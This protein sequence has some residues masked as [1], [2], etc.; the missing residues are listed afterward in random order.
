MNRDLSKILCNFVARLL[1]HQCAVHGILAFAY[2]RP[3]PMTYFNFLENLFFLNNFAFTYEKS[4]R[5]FAQKQEIF[6]TKFSSLDGTFQI[7]ET[8]EVWI[9]KKYF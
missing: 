6:F 7:M 9:P 3:A 5:C 4:N 8:F 2:S 1:V